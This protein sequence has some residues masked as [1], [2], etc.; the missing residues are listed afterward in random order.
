MPSAFQLPVWLHGVVYL[1][2]VLLHSLSALRMAVPTALYDEFIYLGFGRFFAATAPLPNFRGGAFGS[3]GYGLFIAPA[4]LQ[5]ASFLSSYR[6]VLLMNSLMISL[7]Y[8]LLYYIAHSVLR[9]SRPTA[10]LLSIITCLYPSFLLFSNYAISENVFVPV[11][12]LV[13][14]CAVRTIEHATAPTA[15]LM[16][17][18]AGM[19]YTIHSRSLGVVVLTTVLL[20]YLVLTRRLSLKAASFAVAILLGVITMTQIANGL[21]MKR[22][23]GGGAGE[24]TIRHTMTS[25]LSFRGGWTA[26]VAMIGQLFYLSVTTCGLWTAGVIFGVLTIFPHSKHRNPWRLMPPRVVAIAFCLVSTLSVLA[27]SA[28]FVASYDPTLGRPDFLV[29]GRYNEGAVALPILFGLAFLIELRHGQELVRAAKICFFT[30]TLTL[31]LS[32]LFI[33]PRFRDL[34]WLQGPHGMDSMYREDQF[35]FRGSARFCHVLS[36]FRSIAIQGDCNNLCRFSVSDSNL[37]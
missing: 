34:E 23:W 29:T 3:F 37:V 4:F 32:S 8:F 26:L 6:L 12:L 36:H 10:L 16:T 2:L 33:I 14:V 19:L 15:A 11:F 31:V 35:K 20:L 27:V 18:T 24:V 5:S 13:I 25:L 7:S 30:V 9:L 17:L 21:L 28:A 1:A 22:G